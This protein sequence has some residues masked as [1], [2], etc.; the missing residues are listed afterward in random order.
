VLTFPTSNTTLCLHTRR[1]IPQLDVPVATK[2][3]NTGMPF[4]G[5]CFDKDGNWYCAATNGVHKYSGYTPDAASNA[6]NFEFYAQWNNFQ[7]ESRLKHLKEV[8]MVLEAASGQAGTFKWQTDYLAGTT[9]S[10]AFTCDST[11]FAEDPG[12]G[13]VRL[14]IGRSCLV[15]KP[16]FSFAINGD[17]VAIHQLRLFANPGK[18]KP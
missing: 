12:I 2:W 8:A 9:N 4:R 14:P 13:R 7:D 16:G 10:V 5:F 17:A 15:V 6:Y 18:T 3:T 1:M 11:E